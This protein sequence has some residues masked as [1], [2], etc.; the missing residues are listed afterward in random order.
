MYFIFTRIV[1]LSMYI[2]GYDLGKCENYNNVDFSITRQ[3]TLTTKEYQTEVHEIN[4][5]LKLGGLNRLGRD[6]D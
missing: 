4:D 3:N 5:N 2:L 1:I 6:D